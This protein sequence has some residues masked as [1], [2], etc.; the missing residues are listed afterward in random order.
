M[1]AYEIISDGGVEALHLSER[2]L[3]APGPG[4]VNVKMLANSI[5][6]RDLSTIENPVGRGFDYPRVPNSDGAGTITALGVG[7]SSLHVGDKVASCFMQN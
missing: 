2:T 3:A 7:V 5:N 6:Y 4:E 1:R